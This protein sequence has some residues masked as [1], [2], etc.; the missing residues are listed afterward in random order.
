MI[1]SGGELVLADTTPTFARQT[2][3][4]PFGLNLTDYHASY[5]AIYKAQLWVYVLVRKRALGTARLP[6]KVYDRG[7]SDDSGRTSARDT[8]YAQLLRKP[9]PKHDP[10]FFWQWTSSTYDIYGEVL[11]VKLRDPKGKVRELWPL[12]PVNVYTR[13]EDG[14]L[15]YYFF[16]GQSTVPQFAIPSADIVHFKGYNPDTTVR[17][18][19]ALE[20]LRQTLVNE[21]AARRAT[22]SFWRNGARPGVALVHQKTLS[23]PAADRL[24]ARWDALTSGAD[25]TGSSVVLEEGMEPKVMMLTAEE[26]QYIETRKLN[27]EEVCAAYDVPP[28][29]VHILDRATFSNITEQMRSM[30]RDTMAPHLGGFEST[31]DL[32]LRPEFE[33]GGD[34]YAEFLMDEVMR[35]AFETRAEAY[36]KAINSGWMMPGEARALENMR[37][38]EGADRL[39]V[40]ATLIPIDEVSQHVSPNLPAHDPEV[41][42]D[43]AVDVPPP[44]PEDSPPKGRL[45]AGEARRVVDRASRCGSLDDVQPKAL[46]AGMNGSGRLVL[47]LLEQCKAAGDDVATFC[48]LMWALAKE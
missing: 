14:E 36:Q 17:G 22:S 40:N 27:R 38:A 43:P 47:A 8:P 4:A 39:F 28:P 9:N 20:P 13:N 11:W 19:S 5:A 12:H 25:N 24:K 32:Q 30:Y 26:A 15:W 44:A 16:G 10:F 23:E 29:V 34:L 18:M 35:G 37:P 7:S 46:T 3:W 33:S 31:M 1:V 6:L 21:D 45:S 42:I 48:A 2:Y 41:P